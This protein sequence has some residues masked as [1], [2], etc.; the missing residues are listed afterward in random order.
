MAAELGQHFAG[1]QRVHPR[2]RI[3]DEDRS[4]AVEMRPVLLEVVSEALADPV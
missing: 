2:R 4:E 3:G 1:L